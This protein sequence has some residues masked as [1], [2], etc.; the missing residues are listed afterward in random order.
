MTVHW[1]GVKRT[2]PGVARIELGTVA[3]GRVR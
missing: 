2:A 1:V 3:P